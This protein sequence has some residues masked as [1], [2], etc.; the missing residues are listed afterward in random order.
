MSANAEQTGVISHFGRRSDSAGRFSIVRAQHLVERVRLA[1]EYAQQYRN[2][3]LVTIMWRLWSHF[4]QLALISSIC[5]AQFYLILG[6]HR[7][8][9]A[10]TIRVAARPLRLYSRA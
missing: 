3:A 6:E 1:C 4:Y 2:A 9:S 5:F 8:G 7:D 10:F